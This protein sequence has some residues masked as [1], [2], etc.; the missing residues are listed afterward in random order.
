MV[1]KLSISTSALPRQQWSDW[2]LRVTQNAYLSLMTHTK[3]LLLVRFCDPIA[4]IVKWDGT[5]AERCKDGQ[6]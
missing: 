6:L 5:D 1:L 4:G 2:G 3:Q